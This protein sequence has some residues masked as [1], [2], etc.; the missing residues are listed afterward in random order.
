MRFV[1]AATDG[2]NAARAQT[3]DRVS[4][5]FAKMTRDGVQRTI[6]AAMAPRWRTEVRVVDSV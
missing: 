4:I 1:R 3:E 5:D 2:P 6:I